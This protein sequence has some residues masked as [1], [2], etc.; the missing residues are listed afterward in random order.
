MYSEVL[1][2]CSMLFVMY[3]KK[4]CFIKSVKN[5]YFQF[6]DDFERKLCTYLSHASVTDCALLLMVSLVNARH[7][8][9]YEGL[10][11]GQTG[12]K[13][14]ARRQRKS[15]NADLAQVD[16]ACRYGILDDIYRSL[17]QLLCNTSELAMKKYKYYLIN[18]Q[19]NVLE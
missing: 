3:L 1:A 6:F 11:G 7:P 5:K 19:K 15:T 13:L 10:G 8:S 14:E 16:L 12:R 9:L 18:F 17:A 4:F 2:L